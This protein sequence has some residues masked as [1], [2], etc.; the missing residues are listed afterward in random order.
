[1]RWRERARPWSLAD[2][3]WGDREEE[4]EM[5]RE[6]LCRPADKRKNGRMEKEDMTDMWISRLEIFRSV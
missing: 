2:G 4:D 5:Q 6:A 1:M 3:A